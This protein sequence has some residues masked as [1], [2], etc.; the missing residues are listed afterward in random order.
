MRWYRFFR[1][2]MILMIT[3]GLSTP[4]N[5]Q[6][7]DEPS[8]PQVLVPGGMYDK[9][10]ITRLGGRTSLG[11]YAE[12]H[13]RTE[14]V[15][16]VLEEATFQLKRFNLFTYSVINSRIRI[17][18][19]FE[20]EE[21][22]EEIKIEL[23]VIDFEIREELNFRAGIILSPLG[24]FNLSHDGPVNELTDRPLVTTELIPSTLSEP[25]FR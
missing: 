7:S 23:G 16:G 3:L 22:G 10:F 15:N 4:S 9:P 8:T 13:L 11:G 14:R 2:Y 1:G 18:S 5:A 19:E 25:Q 12:F 17:S 20:F 24:R 21:G 6:T